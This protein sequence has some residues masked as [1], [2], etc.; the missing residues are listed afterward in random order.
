[1]RVSSNDKV[2]DFLRDMQSVSPNQFEIMLSIR[3]LFF[4]ANKETVEDIKYGGLVFNVSNSLVGG[5]YAYKKHISIEFSHGVEFT[6]PDTLLE[7]AGKRR[8]HLKIVTLD[9]ITQKNS[10]YFIRQ[11]V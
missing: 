6:D 1:M 7:G 5:I 3:E 10:A 2:N 8:R 9:D 4:D 11:A